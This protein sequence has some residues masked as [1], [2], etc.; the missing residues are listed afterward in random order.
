[1]T[2]DL[3][4]IAAPNRKAPLSLPVAVARITLSSPLHVLRGRRLLALG[5]LSFLAPA[6]VI[7]L[8]SFGVR[9]VLGAEMYRNF[10]SAFYV[11]GVFPLTCLFLGAAAIGDDI[12][13]G[14]ILYLRL[15]P[16]PRAAIVLGRFFAA[17]FSSLALFVP[18]LVLLYVLQVG[19]AGWEFVGR[20]WKLCLGA[21]L[22]A[23]A[24]TIGYC[25]IFLLLGLIARRAVIYGV[26]V[27]AIQGS[28]LA[29]VGPAAWLSV[30][31]YVLT[32]LDQFGMNGEEIGDL[33]LA[34][35]DGG[36]LPSYGLSWIVLTSGASLLLVAA[37]AL[38]A[39]REYME[40]PGE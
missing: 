10:V 12:D 7:A 14:T 38:F 25:A 23:T 32:I 16:L 27:T 26:V 39:S 8:R 28:L 13:D 31:L 35:E 40:K 18:S 6:L 11:N 30:N 4:S 17:V 1:M 19:G 22:G 37:S 3:A 5:L 9:D 29:V 15:R 21:C 24:A 36:Y 34:L 20:Y 2:F 33:L